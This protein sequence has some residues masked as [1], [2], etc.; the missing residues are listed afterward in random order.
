LKY[1]TT[2]NE[3]KDITLDE[4]KA[5]T[6]KS[7]PGQR[8]IIKIEELLF[9]KGNE[10]KIINDRE[11]SFSPTVYIE[12]NITSSAITSFTEHLN[13]KLH[14]VDKKATAL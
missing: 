5:K 4:A 2:A 1:S 13:P 9:K 11:S 8:T 14:D 10:I 3:A 6:T 7:R 12:D